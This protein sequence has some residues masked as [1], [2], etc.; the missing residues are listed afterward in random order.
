MVDQSRPVHLS[1]RPSSRGGWWSVGLAVVSLLALAVF[2]VMAASGERG[3]DGFL[4]NWLLTGPTAVVLAAALA[5]LIAALLAVL[6]SH[7][8][9]LLLALPIAWGLLVAVFTFGEL[10]FP[11]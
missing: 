1:F 11:H 7:E 10:A 5:G 8:R 6:R 4:D 3:G 9:G 2:V